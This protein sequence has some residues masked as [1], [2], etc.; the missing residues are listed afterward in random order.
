MINPITGPTTP[1]LN[2]NE[3]YSVPILTTS[4]NNTNA[5]FGTSFNNWTVTPSSGVTISNPN[6]RSTTIRFNT[7]GT[8]TLTANFMLPGNVPYPATKTVTV[9]SSS[10]VQSAIDFQIFN[11][12]SSFLSGVWVALD[13]YVG[14][15]YT[16]MFSY[17]PA[18]VAS[19][20]TIY[21]YP[22][23]PGYTFTAAP[24]TTISNLQLQFAA[25]VSSNARVTAYIGNGVQA[26]GNMSGGSISLNL[27]N[28]TVPTV[29][30]SRQLLTVYVDGPSMRRIIN[31]DGTTTVINE[32][33]AAAE[34]K[35]ESESQAG[36][37]SK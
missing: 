28:A 27:P 22:N 26:W 25:N 9:A 6:S 10:G 5:P 24:G 20:G 1:A 16:N 13:G 17:D 37:E 34:S 32:E 21:G 29:N 30:G 4:G 19:G 31:P 12:T 36:S 3:T 33:E 35:T 18:G 15:S 23:Y 14:G 11:Y 8:Y 2:T 7:A